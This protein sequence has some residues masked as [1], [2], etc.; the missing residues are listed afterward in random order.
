MIAVYISSIIILIYFFYE[1]FIFPRMMNKDVKDTLTK[2][3]IDNEFTLQN[4]KN[5]LYDFSL[6]NNEIKLLIKVVDVPSNSTITINS[7]TTWSLTWGGSSKNPGRAK[8]NQRYMDNLLPFLSYDK[9]DKKRTLKV[10]L[11][12]KSTEKIQKYLN[13]C[14]IAII[15][16][17]DLCY[18]YKIITYKDIMD[19]YSDLL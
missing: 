12:Y 13:E 11:V 8:P 19:C 6:E 14:E 7:R 15:K 16:Y 10:I 18:D 4:Y 9:I 5:K 17:S 3:A 1:I 2:I